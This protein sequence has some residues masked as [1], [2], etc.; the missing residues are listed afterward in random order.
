LSPSGARPLAGALSHSR[1][2]NCG[3]RKAGDEEENDDGPH[4]AVHS[5][6]LVR[7]VRKCTSALHRQRIKGSSNVI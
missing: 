7:D 2:S 5:V 6:T 1:L 4:Q 3:A